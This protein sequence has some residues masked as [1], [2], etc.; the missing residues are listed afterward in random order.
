MAI[1]P[2]PDD[3]TASEVASSQFCLGGKKEKKKGR[4]VPAAFFF[5]F[6]GQKREKFAPEFRILMHAHMD[7]ASKP[8]D[9]TF[10]PLG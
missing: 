7:G 9:M 1:S 4:K 10:S 5:L 3:L 2:S 8:E 6:S